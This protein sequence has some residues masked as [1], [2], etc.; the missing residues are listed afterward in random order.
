M[1]ATFFIEDVFTI[2]GR[3]TVVTGLVQE[4]TI[5]PGMKGILSNGRE[6]NVVTIE[7]FQKMLQ[8]AEQGQN[9]GLLLKGVK[10]EDI[11]TKTL[12]TFE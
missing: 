11:T 4:G 6:T 12:I 10:K 1:P 3:G 7:S 8:S 5:T 9:C 2:A